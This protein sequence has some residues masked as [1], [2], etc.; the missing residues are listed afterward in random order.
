[1]SNES[2]KYECSIAKTDDEAI[3]LLE[4]GFNYITGIEGMKLFRKRK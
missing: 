4:D 1:M 2:Q 3:Q